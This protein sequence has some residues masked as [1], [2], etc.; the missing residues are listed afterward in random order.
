[1]LSRP[2]PLKKMSRQVISTPSVP[3][4]PSV[5]SI[6]SVLLGEERLYV[7]GMRG[8]LR[9]VAGDFAFHHALVPM[10]P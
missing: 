5:L 8:R 3:S 7:L 10:Q 1:M 9:A 4:V 2:G 6:L